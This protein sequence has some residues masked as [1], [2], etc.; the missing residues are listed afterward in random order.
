MELRSSFSSG[1][2]RAEIESY[3]EGTM[4]KL[5]VEGAQEYDRAQVLLSMREERRW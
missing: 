2:D 1:R 3:I 4:S 5:G